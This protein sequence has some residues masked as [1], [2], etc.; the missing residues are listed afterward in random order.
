MYLL[1]SRATDSIITRPVDTKLPKPQGMFSSNWLVV[2]VS[3][4]D[5]QFRC[6]SL[7]IGRASDLLVSPDGRYLLVMRDWDKKQALNAN[8]LIDLRTGQEVL[9]I[10]VQNY[11]GIRGMIFTED[12]RELVSLEHDAALREVLVFRTIPSGIE[13]ARRQLPEIWKVADLGLRVCQSGRIWF[14][15]GLEHGYTS[16]GLVSFRLKSHELLDQRQEPGFDY[17]FDSDDPDM[18]RNSTIGSG[19]K[20]YGSFSENRRSLVKQT[21]NRVVSALR[22]RGE[23]DDELA[24]EGSVQFVSPLN[25]WSIGPSIPIM[26][27]DGT[28]FSFEISP[29]GQWLADGGERLGSIKPLRDGGLEWRALHCCCSWRSWLIADFGGTQPFHWRN[30]LRCRDNHARIGDN[31]GHH[32]HSFL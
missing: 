20:A 23:V 6:P 14:W 2:S 28:N 25:D 30:D 17:V 9:S 7:P 24:P 27:H 8:S 1:W 11:S 29:D 31:P 26:G 19:W 12:S 4:L 3:R 15:F 13:V 32:V 22:L 16:S 5:G 21:W 10:P 18:C